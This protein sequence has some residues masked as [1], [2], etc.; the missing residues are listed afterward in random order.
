MDFINDLLPENV[1]N[2]LGWTVLHSLWQAAVIALLLTIWLPG[3]EKTDARN[4]YRAACA[5]LFSTFLVSVITFFVLLENG[6]I[7][8]PPAAVVMAPDGAARAI[9]SGQVDFAAYFGQNMPLIVTLW[10]AGLSVFLIKTLGALLFIER[11]KTRSLT[12]APAR[13]V[14]LMEKLKARFGISQKIKLVASGLVKA[15]LTVGWLRPVVLMPVAAANHLTTEQVAAILAHELAHIARSDYLINIVQTV[16]EALYYFNPAVWWMSAL[17]RTEREN[18]CDDMAVAACGNTFTYAKALVAIQQI[19]HQ[20]PALALSLYTN[21]KKLLFRVQRLFQSPDKQSNTMEKIAAFL[22]L[23]AT[24]ILLS[25]TYSDPV[26]SDNPPATEPTLTPLPPSLT[27]PLVVDTFPKGTIHIVKMED[28]KQ[29]EL[30]MKDGE[31]IYL[32]VD[33]KVIDKADYPKYK[34]V[35]EGLSK[36]VPTPPAPPAP[37]SVGAPPAP[38]SP[39]ISTKQNDNKTTVIIEDGENDPVEIKVLKDNDMQTIII[40]GNEIEGFQNED[41][42]IVVI[43]SDTE[44]HQPSS[45]F[46]SGNENDAGITLWFQGPPDD[47]LPPFGPDSEKLVKLEKQLDLIHSNRQSKKMKKQEKALRKHLKELEKELRQLEKEIR[48]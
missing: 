10:L 44:S 39:I 32:E 20:Q 6:G 4:R 13:W 47:H 43:E 48:K 21:R 31:I 38:P 42:T 30:K 14:E 26:V 27:L 22:I 41:K 9:D 1:L 28:D 46:F 19:R 45:F 35:V 16:V 12:A 25:F 17:I 5:A 40:N 15:P 7:G 24:G 18:C 2:A 8:T 34:D 33:G 29:T 37:P 23:L 3:W 11:L 36:N